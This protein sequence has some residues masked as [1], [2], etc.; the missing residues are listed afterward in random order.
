MLRVLHIVVTDAF[1]GVE[2]YVCDVAAATAPR[3]CEVAV[4]GGDPTRMRALLHRR[5]RWE[6]GA[7]LRECVRS[8][9]RLGHWDVCHAHMTSAEA[10]ALATRRVHHAQVMSTRHFAL[11]RGRSPLGRACAP[12]IA[13]RLRREVAISEFVAA[14][15]ER[16]PSTVIVSGVPSSPLLWRREN[17]TVLI[18][19]RLESEKDTITALRAWKDSRLASEGW[20]LRVVGDGSER[21]MLERYVECEEVTGVT[22]AGRTANVSDEFSRAGILFASAPAEPLGLAVLEAM[23]AGVPV[24]ACGAGGHLETVGRLADA[25]LFPPGDPLATAQALR[26]VLSASKRARL[27]AEGRRLVGERFT[28]ERHIDQLLREYELIAAERQSDHSQV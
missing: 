27:S 3:G 10:V 2:R 19:Q 15:V 18:L 7:N 24:V 23:A 26:S 6:P 11:R 14:S 17:R 20:A 5:V 16:P 22:F 8:L 12:W 1:A 9:L 28:M 25:P 21:R 13:S 4:V